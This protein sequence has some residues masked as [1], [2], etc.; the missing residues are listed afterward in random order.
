MPDIA[1]CQSSVCPSR[2]TCHRYAATPGVRQAYMDFEST[3]AGRD[4]CDDFIP[5]LGK[6]VADLAGDLD[7]LL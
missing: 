4:R 6:F 5:A 1:M 3:R 7:A 2:H